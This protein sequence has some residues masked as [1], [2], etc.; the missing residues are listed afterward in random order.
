MSDTPLRRNRDF[1]LLQAGQLLSTAGANISRI[2]FPLL[3]LAVTVADR[4]DRKRVMVAADIVSAS[5]VGVL[6]AAILTHR[7]AAAGSCA[8]GT[9]DR[10]APL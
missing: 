4:F 1:V 10:K 5:A 8:R 9:T 6:A 2:A 7:F 3:V